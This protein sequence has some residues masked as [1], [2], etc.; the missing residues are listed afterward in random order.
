MHLSSVRIQNFRAFDDVTVGFNNY[1]CMVGPNGGGKSTVLTALNVFFR[2]PG[3]GNTDLAKLDKEDFHHKNTAVPIVITV[4]FS[5]LSAEAQ[6]DLKDYYRHGKLI[7]SARAC[8]NEDDRYAQVTQ[9][10]LRLGIDDFKPF[11]KAA[12]DAASVKELKEIYATIRNK[13]EELPAP[14]TK[15]SMVDALR[16]YEAEH[17]DK[18]IEIPS[19]DQFYGV[20]KGANRLGKYIQWV[21]VPAVKDASE[22]A[23]EAKKAALGILL[24]RTV[25][26]KVSF[27]AALD[28]IRLEAGKKYK[29]VV[30]GQQGFLLDLSKSLTERLGQ[31][32]HPDTS[33][34]LE[35]QNDEQGSIR[36]TEPLAGI[37]AGEGHFTGNL[38]RFGHGL[39][40]SFLLSL[41]EELSASS[42]EGP[43][44]ILGCE[45]PEL[46]QHP[47]QARHLASVFHELATKNSEVIVCTHSPYFVSGREVEDIRAI[48][49]KPSHKCCRCYQATF[50]E[51]ANTISAATGKKPPKPAG[52]ML[53]VQQA[54]QPEL[55][56]MFFTNVLVLVEG[57]EDVAYISA[58]MTL[59][60]QLRE[61]RRLGCHIVPAGGKSELARPIAIAQKLDIPTFVVFDS[62]GHA[63][64]QKG[65]PDPNGR[66]STHEKDNTV[67][68]KLC[69][70]AAPDA[71]PPSTLWRGNLTMWKTEMGT[72]VQED[73]GE[74]E[75]TTIRE[76]VRKNRC[77]DEGGLNK[78][79][80]FIGYSLLAAWEA[81]KRSP[82]LQKLC[83][84]IIAFAGASRTAT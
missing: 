23:V 44:L 17:I 42:A 30:E 53:K 76:A 51:I 81:G 41:L 3:A 12:G 43:R 58:Y 50:E 84:A 74:A 45:E 27:K 77:I 20:S 21:F 52:L 40:R 29:E 37:V 26:A 75:W 69:G 72:V 38:T 70:I 34:S 79:S 33:V 66:R 19:E 22:E 59:S 4:T 10:G 63:V 46:Y 55:N 36:I 68:L 8:W 9:Y 16:Q 1:T 49:P 32:A 56:E 78:N 82:T 39:Q 80:L 83:D 47:P 31:W 35:W 2:E 61:F 48:R 54:L 18:C 57:L 13:A 25:R 64:P 14:S 6:E 60:G 28:G 65:D 24:E 15:Q 73:F 7:V 62:D 71:F 11:F 5:E 67:I